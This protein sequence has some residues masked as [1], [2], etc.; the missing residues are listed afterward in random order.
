MDEIKQINAKIKALVEARNY[1]L[2]QQPTDMDVM[3]AIDGKIIE[4]SAK[5]S[6]LMAGPPIPPLPPAIVAAIGA[7]VA[8]RGRTSKASATATAILTA[9]T[10][11]ANAGAHG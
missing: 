1:L 10:E 3:H 2:H 4:L 7:A 6:A 8:S 5:A 9:A 11:L